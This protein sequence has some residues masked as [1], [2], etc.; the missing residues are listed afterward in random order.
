M[1]QRKCYYSSSVKSTG[2][3]AVFFT[4][5]SDSILVTNKLSSSADH[6]EGDFFDCF[7]IVSNVRN[8]MKPSEISCTESEINTNHSETVQPALEIYTQRNFLETAEGDSS[9]SPGDCFFEKKAPINQPTCVSLPFLGGLSSAS[10]RSWMR[11]WISSGC[12]VVL[13]RDSLQADRWCPF[14]HLFLRIAILE[15]PSL[16][17]SLSRVKPTKTPPSLTFCE[18]E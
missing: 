7:L 14:F 2:G 9:S 16:S 18:A 4:P 15:N 10:V 5:T 3:T 6:V 8:L 17:V 13:V 12:V 11:S 1:C